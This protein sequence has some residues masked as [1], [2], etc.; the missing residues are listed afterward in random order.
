L[1]KALEI[2]HK[3]ANINKSFAGFNRFLSFLSANLPVSLLTLDMLTLSYSSEGLL[4]HH[5][6][7]QRLVTPY[8]ESL[9]SNKE[10]AKLPLLSAEGYHPKWMGSIA[11]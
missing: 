8:P 4:V 5:Y 3:L 1:H 9:N 6:C 11:L 10:G 2:C 7:Q